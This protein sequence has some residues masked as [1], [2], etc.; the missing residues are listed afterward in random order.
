MAGIE[1]L[2]AAW[3]E[4]DIKSYLT[5]RKVLAILLLQYYL[6]RLMRYLLLYND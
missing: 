4:I 1:N 5:I 3:C 6:A 2:Y